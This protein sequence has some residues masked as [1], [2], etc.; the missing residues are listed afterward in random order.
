MSSAVFERKIR[1]PL[2]RYHRD[3]MLDLILAWAE[4]DNSLGL[5]LGYA[6]KM[7][8]LDAADSHGR[9]TVSEKLKR[10]I[11]ATRQEARAR[12][13]LFLERQKIHCEIFADARNVIAHSKCLGYDAHD[14]EFVLFAKHER[15]QDGLLTLA[16]PLQEMERAEKWARR[17]NRYILRT[18]K[19]FD[20]NWV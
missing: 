6:I 4:L 13:E 18:L 9:K 16:V 10:L 3:G 5:L 2:E 8:P 14:P 1:L 7:E 12:T 17:V 20:P 11:S 19:K 15:F